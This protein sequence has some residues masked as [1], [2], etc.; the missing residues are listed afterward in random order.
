[1]MELFEFYSVVINQYLN[2]ECYTCTPRWDDMICDVADED[3][4]PNTVKVYKASHH[5]S[6]QRYVV[7]LS[8]QWSCNQPVP[9]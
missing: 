4:H 6:T 9:S 5:S 3:L 2:L 7:R 1:M 8:Q